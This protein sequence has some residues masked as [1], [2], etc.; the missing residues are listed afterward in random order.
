MGELTIR[1]LRAS[2]EKELG[3][4]FDIRAFH[5]AI[6]E[7]GSVPLTTL[8]GVVDEFIKKQKAAA[9]RTAVP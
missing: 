3:S 1:D 9:N 2:A 6:L 8:R 4:N 5:D 7:N